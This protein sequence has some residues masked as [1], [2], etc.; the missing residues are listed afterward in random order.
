MNKFQKK[1]RSRQ[2]T[3][4][5]RHETVDMVARRLKDEYLGSE[6]GKE[7]ALALSNGQ[8]WLEKMVLDRIDDLE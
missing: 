6:E 1:V 3:I 4:K 7:R 5:E 8:K 2:E